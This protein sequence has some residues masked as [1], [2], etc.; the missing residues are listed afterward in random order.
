MT[1]TEILAQSS[2]VGTIMLAKELGKDRIDR[3]LRSFGFGTRTALG[4]EN[5]SPGLLLP[6]ESWSG[7][8][9][10]S[11]PIGH[12]L[13]VTAMQNLDAYNGSPH[14]ALHV[15]PP[16]LSATADACGPRTPRYHA[17]PRRALAS[18]VEPRSGQELLQ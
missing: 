15:P 7:T 9:I 11:I 2:N 10:G 12:G 17:A 3:Y 14:D 8:S 18:S 1:V 4:F 16:L 5:E 6:T 13:A